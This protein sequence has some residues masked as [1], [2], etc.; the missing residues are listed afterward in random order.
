[1]FSLFQQDGLHAMWTDIEQSIFFSE[2]AKSMDA[3]EVVPGH[4]EG[5]TFHTLLI[6]HIACSAL[7]IAATQKQWH[8]CYICNKP[9]LILFH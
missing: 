5:R 9:T 2:G 7:H 3:T 8:L 1:M 6:Y 4:S